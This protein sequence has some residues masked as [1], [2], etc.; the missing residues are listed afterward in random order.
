M[1]QQYTLDWWPREKACNPSGY[2]SF[3]RGTL[4]LQRSRRKP[5]FGETQAF[6]DRGLSRLSKAKN[7]AVQE[8]EVGESCPSNPSLAGD[9]QLQSLRSHDQQRRALAD[10]MRRALL[11]LMLHATPETSRT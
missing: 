6:R 8:P 11:S 9:L 7:A 4:Q 2:C 10:P 1:L 3:S 5:G